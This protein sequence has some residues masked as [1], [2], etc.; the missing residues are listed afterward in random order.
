MS[1]TILLNGPFYLILI[2]ELDTKI[3]TVKE[4]KAETKVTE[5]ICN[6]CKLI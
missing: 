3:N 1:I 5:T 4:I 2:S 6:N